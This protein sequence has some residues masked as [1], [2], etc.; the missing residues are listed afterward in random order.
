MAVA[1]ITY[2]SGFVADG[3]TLIFLVLAIVLG[4][5]TPLVCIGLRPKP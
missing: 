5:L 1:A 4:G 3:G 2:G